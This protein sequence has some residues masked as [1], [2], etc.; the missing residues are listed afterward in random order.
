MALFLRK[1]R[2]ICSKYLKEV[3]KREAGCHSLWGR[4][5]HTPCTAVCGSLWLATLYKLRYGRKRTFADMYGHLRTAPGIVSS[6]HQDLL[7]QRALHFS[8][9]KFFTDAQLPLTKR[10]LD[11]LVCHFYPLY[12][13]VLEFFLSIYYISAFFVNLTAKHKK[14]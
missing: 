2:G 12:D 13:Y 8:A 3:S 14:N 6:L 1:K 9:D 5:P 7:T 10:T 11:D 4:C